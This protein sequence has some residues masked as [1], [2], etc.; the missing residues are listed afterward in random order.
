[1]RREEKQSLPAVMTM[2]PETMQIAPVRYDHWLL[3]QRYRLLAQVGEGGFGVIYK[4]IDTFLGGRCVAIKKISGQRLSP[5]QRMEANDSLKREAFLMSR[6]MHPNIPRVYDF[7]R[8]GDSSYLV[9]DFIEG[10]TLGAYLYRMGGRLPLEQVLHIGIQLSNVFAYLHTRKVPIIYRDLKPSNSM[11]TPDGH[12]YLIDFGIART[13]KPGQTRDTTALGTPGYSAPE[14]FGQAQTTPRSDIY[15][16]GA[17]LHLLLTGDDP[18]ETP[19]RF[20]PLQL[21]NASYAVKLEELIRQMLHME[22]YRRPA[23]MHVVKQRLQQIAVEQKRA[24][25]AAARATRF[26]QRYAPLPGYRKASRMRE[27]VLIFLSGSAF[28]GITTSLL[29]ALGNI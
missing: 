26:R 17:M 27:S 8:E 21:G 11:L 1:M 4:A 6:L 24:V 3:K 10:E 20:A 12:L 19:F 23:S 22:E 13:F 2:E 7:F 15:S 29:W 14:Q 5:E 16:L 9:M 28:A 25:R 18:A